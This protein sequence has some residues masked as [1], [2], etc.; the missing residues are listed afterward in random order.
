[1]MGLH[2][3]PWAMAMCATITVARNTESFIQSSLCRGSGASDWNIPVCE[4]PRVR[5]QGANW[6]LMGTDPGTD[7]PWY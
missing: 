3:C 7:R 1:M 5:Y 2:A 6:G 4:L